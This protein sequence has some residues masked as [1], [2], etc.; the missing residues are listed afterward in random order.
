MGMQAQALQQIEN[1]FQQKHICW[2]QCK[3]IELD[4]YQLC[5]SGHFAVNLEALWTIRAA[6][7]KILFCQTLIYWP[8][9]LH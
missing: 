2:L 6:H 7:M 5:L 9:L 3:F 4:I 8:G 1:N